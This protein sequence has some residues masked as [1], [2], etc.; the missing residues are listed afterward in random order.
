LHRRHHEMRRAMAPRLAKQ[1]RHAAI[2]QDRE[3]LQTERR[4]TPSMPLAIRRR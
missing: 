1:V 2:R 4:A 3:A